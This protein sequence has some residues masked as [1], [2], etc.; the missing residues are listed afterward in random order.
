MSI[1]N[2]SDAVILTHDP[3][4]CW[5]NGYKPHLLEAWDANLDVNYILNSYGA[6]VYIKSYITK[7]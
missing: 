4:D 7:K 6:I 1:I 2:K 5:V 3:K